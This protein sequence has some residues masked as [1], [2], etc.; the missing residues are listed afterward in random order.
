[1]SKSE[2]LPVRKVESILE[3]IQDAENRIRARAFEISAGSGVPGRDLDNWLQAE[4]ELALRPA[5]ELREKD[6]QFKLKISVP[7]VEPKAMVI[8][9][10][11]DHILVK[12]ELHHD[13]EAK[14]GDVH[15]CEFMSVRLFRAVKLP[16]KIDP[17]KVKAE[18]KNG[19]LLLTADIAEPSRARKVSVQTA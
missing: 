17:D 15:A 19:M 9:A 18:V 1:M 14:D 12:A 7:G 5:I 4:D 6:K 10:T 16:K 8:E 11:P 3:E 2:T 13:H